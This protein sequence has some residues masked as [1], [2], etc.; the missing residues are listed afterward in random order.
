VPEAKENIFHL[1]GLTSWDGMEGYSVIKYAKQ[2][3]NLGL[4]LRDYGKAFFDNNCKP[5]YVLEHPGM[6]NEDAKRNILRSLKSQLGSG[7][8][9]AHKAAVL[10][11]GMK[12]HEYSVNAE[13]AQ[14]IETRQ[15]ETRE[16]A[17]WFG[18]PP[19][20]LGDDTRTS[21]NSLEQENQSYLDALDPWLHSWERESWDKLLTEEE[22]DSDEYTFEFN[23]SALVKV[24]IQAR[25][26]AYAIGL[27]GKAFLTPNEVRNFENLEPLT[28]EEIKELNPVPL[29]PKVPGE[30]PQPPG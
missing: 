29:P 20:K 26:A 13:D 3:F 15:F 11:E 25:Y 28:P 17:S 21:Y 19:H 5:S 30:K 23:R 6:L 14:L 2:S 10:W 4:S 7:A 27:A 22:K 12:L 18:I 16:V 1:K 9:N 24:N 8:S